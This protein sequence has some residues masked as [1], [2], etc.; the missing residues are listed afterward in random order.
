MINFDKMD[1]EI[2]LEGCDENLEAGIRSFI[3]ALSQSP[4]YS[5]LSK[6]YSV[7]T[8]L[9]EHVDNAYLDYE[10]RFNL[11]KCGFS[12]RPSRLKY[13]FYLVDQKKSHYQGLSSYNKIL[14]S[15][16]IWE[17]RIRSMIKDS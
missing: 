6:R 15:L 12:L 7:F 8:L 1:E 5:L 17:D 4:S 2:L 10:K 3:K 14:F 11:N 16:R 13:P 9:R